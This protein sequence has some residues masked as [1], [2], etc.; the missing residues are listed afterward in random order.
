MFVFLAQFVYILAQVLT[1]AIIIRAL[2]S[3]FMPT[4]GGGFMRVLYDITEPVLGP[5]RRILPAMGGIDF[6][7]IVAM[8]IIWVVSAVLQQLLLSSA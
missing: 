1:F 2:A 6:S 5:V 3:W 8:I 7:P 4:G